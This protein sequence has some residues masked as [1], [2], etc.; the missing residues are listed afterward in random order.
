MISAINTNISIKRRAHRRHS[1]ALLPMTIFRY[2]LATATY[3][4]PFNLL[5]VDAVTITGAT[6]LNSISNLGFTVIPSIKINYKH[7]DNI[8]N[9][10]THTQASNVIEIMPSLGIEGEKYNNKFTLGYQAKKTLYSGYA[11]LN[12]TDHLF[13][14][15]LSRDIS[16]RH[17][18]ALSY[19]F[20]IGHDA[21]NTGISE[22][23]EQIT[24]PT[25]F[26]AQSVQ[27]NYSYGSRTASAILAP[28]LG[29]NNKRY[30]GDGHNKV[31]QANF[32]EYNYGLTLYYNMAAS[33]K[34]LLDVSNT[35][36]DYTDVNTDKGSSN[37]LLYTG[38]DWDLSGKT[39][40]TLKVGYES[41]NF[42]DITKK[43]QTNPS[44]DIGIS[45][46]P[47]TYS[48][49]TVN[50]SQKITNAITGSNSIDTNTAS[51]NWEHTWRY[52]LSSSLTYS[53]LA[54]K[55]QQSMREDRSYAINIAFYYQFKYWL[56]L[57]LSYEYKEKSSSDSRLEYDKSIY[58]LTSTITF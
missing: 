24:T 25:G 58:G 13:V 48:I 27:V 21:V 29:F 43:S 54:E 36:T 44:W 47:K 33:L 31:E 6:D 19:D 53:H 34:L 8:T 41:I 45:W 52:N 51:I 40:G 38:I 11:D 55:Y 20:N 26:Y 32:D 37:H 14:S 5:A 4:I 16:N 10:K 15:S 17:R 49:F 42:A 1:L 46:F 22:G 56:A 30:A 35:T 39:Q 57:G 28:R 50:T 12:Y 9:A 3:F 2:A 7:D 23:N 18:F